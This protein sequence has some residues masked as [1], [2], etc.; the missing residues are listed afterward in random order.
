MVCPESTG[1]TELNAI[2]T[3]IRMTM[4]HLSMINDQQPNVP[5]LIVCCI[6]R[7]PSSLQA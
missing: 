1:A 4:N 5:M 3:G 7:T 6:L 2:R